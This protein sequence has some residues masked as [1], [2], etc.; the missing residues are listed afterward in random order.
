M[1]IKAG[2]QYNA[3]SSVESVYIF[4]R[5]ANDTGI[6][7]ESIGALCCVPRLLFHSSIICV[8]SDMHAGSST[9]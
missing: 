9:V 1:C 4:L 6:E 7:L 3:G 5:N 8:V 2:S